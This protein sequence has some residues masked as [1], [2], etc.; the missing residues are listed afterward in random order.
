MDI[1]KIIGALGLIFIIIS[2][3]LKSKNRKTRDIMYIF[4]GVFLAVY[5]FY[6]KDMIFI[7][8][9]IVFIIVAIYDFIKLKSK[10]I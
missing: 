10:Y 5:S 7:V 1:F 3:L 6:I 2:I 8:L 9:Q 4:G